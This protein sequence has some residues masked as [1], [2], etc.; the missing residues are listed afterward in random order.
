[1]TTMPNP[2]NPPG[3]AM[4]QPNSPTR[5]SSLVTTLLVITVLT[6]IVVAFLQSMSI[7]RMTAKSY[8]NIEQARL[9]AEA[10][11]AEAES[12]LVR[13]FNEFPDSATVWETIGETS[14]TV[15]YLRTQGTNVLE[16]TTRPNVPLNPAAQVYFRPLI[17]GVVTNSP[18]G[19]NVKESAIPSLNETNSVD[20]NAFNHKI[21]RRLLG[22]IPGATAETNRIPWVYIQDSS[23]RNVARFAYLVE[24]ESF[25]VNVTLSGASDRQASQGTNPTEVSLLPILDALKASGGNYS[26]L[27]VKSLAD[28]LVAARNSLPGEGKFIE[29]GQLNRVDVKFPNL[30]ED[31][32]YLVTH[33]SGTLNLT[34]HGSKRVNINSVVS[35]SNDPQEV[36]RQVETI[37]A[38]INF[39]LPRFG[40]R[41]YRTTPANLNTDQVTSAHAQVYVT[42]LAANLRDMIDTDSQPTVVNTA[43]RS[44][45]LGSN[46]P[47]PLRAAGFPV[48]GNSN[49][50]NDVMAYG[51]EA[52]P[53]LQEYAL[54]AKLI[55]M[56][57][58]RRTSRPAPA[59]SGI[60]E[61]AQYSLTLDHYFEFW[62]LGT[63]DIRLEDLG[64]NPFLFVYAQPRFDTAGGDDIPEGRDFRIPLGDFVDAAGNPLIFPA[65][66]ATVLTTDS[67]PATT[68]TP[69]SASVYRPKTP[70]LYLD[71]M[72]RNYRE[73]SGQTARVADGSPSAQNGWFRVNI[74][75]RS[76]S[77]TDYQT[78]V[79]LGNDL[80]IL[81]SFCALPIPANLS[82][83]NDNNNRANSVTYFFRGGSLRGNSANLNQVADPRTNAEQ[84]RIQRWG[85]GSTPGEDQ[86][87]YF[88]NN[89]NNGNV[90]AD[91]NFGNP[92]NSFT[93]LSQWPD[94]ASSYTPSP[95]GAIAVNLDRPL[96]SIGELGH[97][98]DPARG[99]NNSA[100]GA[101]FS[102]GGGR[103]LRIGQSD[104]STM[105]LNGL[106]TGVMSEA[107]SET[108]AWRLTD[109]FSVQDDLRLPGRININGI[110]RD[111]GFA[112]RS[113]IN[114]LTFENQVDSDS[115]TAGRSLNA[116]A[117][118]SQMLNRLAPVNPSGVRRSSAETI[119][120]ERGALS[121]LSIFS[122]ETSL[123]G[124]NMANARDRAREELVRRLI[125]LVC[126]KGDTYKIHCIGQ[127]V[128]EE[129]SGRMRVGSSSVRTKIVRVA[130]LFDP[131]LDESINP[132]QQE[133]ILERFR[134]P[135]RYGI[136]SIR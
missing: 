29:D 111:N 114:G 119:F 42:K 23:G 55:S 132:S 26:S 130:P 25:K 46:A 2:P 122:Q 71:N 67:T 90:P 57:P 80:G 99:I 118:I 47:T 135:T 75:P 16:S 51:K 131:P 68:L 102:R 44:I 124:A 72:G 49:G 6:I 58:S 32:E 30:R 103:T 109:V 53:F 78:E 21:G 11:V 129:A 87:R 50:E 100:G 59:T 13:L 76:T 9:A 108:A 54:R 18:F 39:H 84:L 22:S 65:G 95:T 92:I 104:N 28:Q 7:E 3:S 1:M 45:R 15:A 125:E 83:N 112:L 62:N 134:R 33:D 105:N 123:N 94:S 89:L 31:L 43:N 41:F 106:S 20:I 127:S 136:I 120:W 37:V 60:P 117:L 27:D 12:V 61:S 96:T 88:N 56:T 82:I 64:P 38:A 73:F 35:D 63:K 110:M 97:V 14:S 36:S 66:Q 86:T 113:A 98:F 79:V 4:P 24:D 128:R 74:E 126:V 34:R 116:D 107:S 93:D 52:V 133:T 115:L 70:N 91:S 121:E 8:S 48:G 81:E 85:S 5:G 10:G 40:Q 77:Q 69:N 101:D 19:H 17:S